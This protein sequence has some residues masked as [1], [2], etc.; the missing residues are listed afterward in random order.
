[1]PRI[2]AKHEFEIGQVVILNTWHDEWCCGKI[3]RST[4]D[5]E[6]CTGIKGKVKLIV[7]GHYRDCD[8]TPL[9]VLSSDS[10]GYIS[11][12]ESVKQQTSYKRWVDLFITGISE[13][14]LQECFGEKV[15]LKHKSVF[16]F[17][18]QLRKELAYFA[19]ES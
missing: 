2:D 7:V 15:E 3:L 17:E 13:D 19:K 16:E 14:H 4:R 11:G 1:M 9:Y 5:K 8:G 6:I 18:E 12:Y 10:I